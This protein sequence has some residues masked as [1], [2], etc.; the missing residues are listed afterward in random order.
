MGFVKFV[1]RGTM[2]DDAPWT[3][4]QAGGWYKDMPAFFENEASAYRA[5]PD[6][7]TYN[8]FDTLDTTPVDYKVGAP[9]DPTAYQNEYIGNVIG[10][11]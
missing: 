2:L 9:V 4:G 6:P 8:V 7:M 11:Y 5:A 10:I 3:W 1:K